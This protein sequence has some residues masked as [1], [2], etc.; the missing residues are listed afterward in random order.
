MSNYFN[1]FLHEVKNDLDLDLK[2]TIKN[3]SKKLHLLFC[4]FKGNGYLCKQ[5]KGKQT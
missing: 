1:M 4:L 2:N 5:K 3:K